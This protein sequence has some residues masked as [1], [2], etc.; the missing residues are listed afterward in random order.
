MNSLDH[1]NLALAA[2]PLAHA[3][4]LPVHFP[5]DPAMAALDRRVV[6]DRV[7]QLLAH[8]CQRQGPGDH[9]R[10]DFAGLTLT[11]V[12]RRARWR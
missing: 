7:W 4:A 10:A 11:A 1:P 3:T 2:Q 12:R 9:V 6:F 5:T 8:V